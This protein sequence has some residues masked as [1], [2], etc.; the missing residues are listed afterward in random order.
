M[1]SYEEE[2]DEYSGDEEEEDRR[3]K[4]D[5]SRSRSPKRRANKSSKKAKK[6]ASSKAKNLCPGGD[7]HKAQR[8]EEYEGDWKYERWE[9]TYNANMQNAKKGGASVKKRQAEL[10]WE[11]ER[12]VEVEVE[13]D[14]YRRLDIANVEDKKAVEVKSGKYVCLDEFTKSEVKRD[15]KLVKQGWEI[16]WFFDNEASGPLVDKLNEKGITVEFRKD[17]KGKKEEDEEDEEEDDSK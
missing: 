3:K 15:G 6:K 5:R 2:E 16:E 4:R 1:D 14:V 17:N 8:W 9:K 12:E 13:E 7:Q 10:D 11:S